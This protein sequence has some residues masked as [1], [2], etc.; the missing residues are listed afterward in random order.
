MGAIVVP[1]FRPASRCD[2]VRQVR[3]VR[4]VRQ[5]ATRCGRSASFGALSSCRTRRTPSHRLA[6]LKAGTTIAPRRTRRIT[7]HAAEL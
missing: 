7:P 6:G 1:A 3:R 4:R 5:G 2:E